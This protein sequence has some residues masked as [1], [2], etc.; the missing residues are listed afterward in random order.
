MNGKQRMNAAELGALWMT[1]QKKT[2]ILRFLDVFIAKSE[3]QEAKALMIGLRD[4]LDP[5]VEELKKLLQ[6]E[7]A[8]IPVGFTMSDINL[9]APKLFA[10]GFDILFARIL[11]EISMGLYSL[12]LAVSYRTDIIKLYMELTQLT[13][14][15]YQQFTHYLVKKEYLLMPA[16]ISMPQSEDSIDDKSY[17][18]GTNLFGKKRPLTAIEYSYL[19]HSIETN[20][21]G[22][23]LVA[24]FAQTTKNEELKKYFLKGK[25]LAQEI[26][27]GTRKMLEKEGFPVQDTSS[28]IVTGSTEAPFSD[29]LMMFCVYLLSN[30]SL[31]SQSFGFGFSLRNDLDIQF[32]LFGKDIVAYTREGVS[33]MIKNGWLEE[34][35][36]MEQS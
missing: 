33:L 19:Y 30:F 1:Y 26:A 7:G 24:G 35:P 23:Q 8:D 2:T 22:M 29:K 5:K 9:E 13:Q 6:N 16:V 31:G 27:A 21:T 28:G 11:K 17:R 34:P 10:N 3:E 4:K 20:Q 12:H 25:N 36:R 18:K 15:Y 32:G 14:Y